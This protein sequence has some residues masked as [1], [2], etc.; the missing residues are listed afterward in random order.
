M[1]NYGIQ[2]RK[3][4]AS[5]L[6]RSWPAFSDQN[7][8]AWS[9]SHAMNLDVSSLSIPGVR[10]DFPLDDQQHRIVH[11]IVFSCCHHGG[12]ER[13]NLLH[14]SLD[15]Q[16]TWQQPRPLGSSA[17]T[18]LLIN[19]FWD[20]YGRA[21]DAWDTCW[22]HFPRKTDQLLR[23][24]RRQRTVNKMMRNSSDRW[25]SHEQDVTANLSA[26]ASVFLWKLIDWLQ[27]LPSTR[28]RATKHS[29]WERP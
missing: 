6:G 1:I 3:I 8:V 19:G 16:L 24:L 28:D 11:G 7:C 13:F 23:L 29:N 12:S 17:G 22:P 27:R 20:E 5:L 18:R 2:N 21:G 25:V 15:S 10:D 4:I 9:S 26:V 14:R